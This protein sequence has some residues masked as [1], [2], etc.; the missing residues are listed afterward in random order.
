MK[1][2]HKIFFAIPFDSATKN[3]YDRISKKIRNRYP[4]ITTVTGNQE[5]GPSPEY[6][7]FA[8]FKAQN[9]ELTRQFV[10][11][12]MDADIIVADLT[13]NNPNVHV[14]LGIALTQ[15]KNIL[16]VTGRSV[17]E[18]GFDIRNLEVRPYKTEAELAKR[19]MAYL[20]TFFKI[21]KIPI[22]KEF[23]PLYCE[24]PVVPLLLR[25]MKT[26]LDLQSKCPSD[27]LIR[28]GAVQVDFEILNVRTQDDWFGIYFR[29]GA[30]PLMGS[31]LVYARQSGMIEIAVYPGP[32]VIETLSTGKKIAGRQ[33]MLIEFENNQ[34]KLQMG[35]DHLKTDKL[36]HQTAGRVWQA[37]WHAN[38]DVHSV[39]MICRDT[40]EWDQTLWKC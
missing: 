6:S 28:D 23:A 32:H 9:R 4:K 16:R 36:S 5:V 27:F 31:H 12:I 35:K 3:L 38:V 34:L 29:A 2:S 19:I 18:L 39:K 11:Q 8:S 22:S 20:D 25:G 1:T 10:D 21:K 40:I 17:S 37:A 30:N 14:E 13:H 7:D 15:N 33:S 24:E 26:E